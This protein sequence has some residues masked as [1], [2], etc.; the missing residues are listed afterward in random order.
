MNHLLALK[1][2]DPIML[3]TILHHTLGRR[4]KLRVPFAA[5][6]TGCVQPLKILHLMIFFLQW[7][8]KNC[9]TVA[10]FLPFCCVLGPLV[11]F[12]SP[13]TALSPAHPIMNY[14]CFSAG[15]CSSIS[16]LRLPYFQLY[17]GCMSTA[18]LTLIHEDYIS[19][20]ETWVIN[21]I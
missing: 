16:T 2:E 4:A 9:L 12:K 6:A 19:V 5:F 13:L 10:L 14:L 1:K 20:G 18:A 11:R 7:S 8:W 15:L 17:R 21:N 3:I